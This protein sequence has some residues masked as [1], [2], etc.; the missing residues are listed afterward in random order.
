MVVLRL[1]TYTDFSPVVLVCGPEV[2]VCGAARCGVVFLWCRHPPKRLLPITALLVSQKSGFAHA[3]A[4][5]SA[6]AAQPGL[7][8]A[9][10]ARR[11]ECVLVYG[12]GLHW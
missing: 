4:Q 10:V 1:N 8:L 7:P 3:H 12:C 6:L 2:C 5:T 11:C 9:P